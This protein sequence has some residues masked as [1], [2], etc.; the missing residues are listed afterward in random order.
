[1]RDIAAEKWSAR[2]DSEVGVGR[3]RDAASKS[4][5]ASE[6]ALTS[7]NKAAAAAAAAASRDAANDNGA[8]SSILWRRARRA[9]GPR[10]MT[11]L[12]VGNTAAAAAAAAAAGTEFMSS[13]KAGR[14][15]IHHRSRQFPESQRTVQDYRTWVGVYLGL[16]SGVAGFCQCFE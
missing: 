9:C 3:W 5:A 6:R 11:D 13:H 4:A 1:M 14:C 2:A 15:S 16:N 12:R 10:L 8:Q 7:G